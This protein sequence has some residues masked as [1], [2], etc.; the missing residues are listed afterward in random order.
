MLTGDARLESVLPYHQPG[1]LLGFPRLIY[2]ACSVTPTPPA[3]SPNTLFLLLYRRWMYPEPR[4]AATGCILGSDE[5]VGA[6]ARHAGVH[7]A[8]A[9]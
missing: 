2:G 5:V 8:I 7:L 9:T 1:V 6:S 4:L 3:P